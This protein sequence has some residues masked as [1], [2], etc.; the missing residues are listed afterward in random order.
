[1]PAF[2]S[3]WTDEIA[4]HLAEHG[5][6]QDDPMTPPQIRCVTRELTPE[7][8]ERLHK[9]RE[10]IASELPGLAER[11]RMRKPRSAAS[12][13]APSMAVHFPCPR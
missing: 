2:D 11:D 6:S 10:Q 1:M 7:E 5:L 12:C 9:Y 4:E 13:V 8:Q 3:L